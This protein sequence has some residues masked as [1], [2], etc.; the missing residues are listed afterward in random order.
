MPKKMDIVN[1][2][3][4]DFENH[5]ILYVVKLFKIDVCI[6]FGY[7]KQLLYSF[8]LSK[9]KKHNLCWFNWIKGNSTLRLTKYTNMLDP[10]GKNKYPYFYKL[11]EWL[12]HD[13]LKEQG[14]LLQQNKEQVYQSSNCRRWIASNI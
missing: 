13:L 8:T 11:M 1:I 9:Y 6:S 10:L 12:P 2:G 7:V 4:E 3:W 5:A 14:C